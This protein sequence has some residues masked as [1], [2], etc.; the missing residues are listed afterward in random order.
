V[1]AKD[2]HVKDMKQS[3][4]MYPG[5]LYPDLILNVITMENQD[6]GVLTAGIP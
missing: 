5:R 3:S 2:L 4:T 1:G 6:V